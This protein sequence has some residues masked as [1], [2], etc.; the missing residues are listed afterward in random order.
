M[1]LGEDEVNSAKADL[2]NM[3][4]GETTSVSLT[5]DEILKLIR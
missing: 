1:I 3:E 2:K 4:T 5:A